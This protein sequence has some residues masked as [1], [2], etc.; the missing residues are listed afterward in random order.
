MYELFGP[1]EIGGILEVEAG[2]GSRV[3]FRAHPAPGAASKQA[4]EALATIVGNAEQTLSSF[5]PLHFDAEAQRWS[6]VKR[7]L[8]QEPSSERPQAILFEKCS[9]DGDRAGSVFLAVG[10]QILLEN[11]RGECA[12]CGFCFDEM[13]NLRPR[14]CLWRNGPEAGRWRVPA[15]LDAA[16][17]Q[18]RNFAAAPT[19]DGWLVAVNFP[20]PVTRLDA[21]CL[22]GLAVYEGYFDVIAAQVR[23]T[24]RAF[25]Y[26]IEALA[27]ASEAADGNTGAHIHRVN[28]YS[29]A[30]AE[31]LGMSSDFVERISYSAQMHDVGKLHIP[32]AIL[33]KPGPLT[34]AE[35]EVMKRHKT[36]G[37]Q[38]LGDSPR[39]AMARE[40]ALG[41]HE[42]WD[43]SG[44]PLRLRG[45]EIPLSA[46]IVML[47]DVYDALRS[48]RPYKDG[49]DH[50]SAY[51]AL[52]RGDGRTEPGHF[53]PAILAAFTRI[54]A[55]F[56]KI[57][58]A[59]PDPEPSDGRQATA[60]T[61]PD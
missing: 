42:R 9:R 38:I 29:A 15:E 12:R 20:R 18:I 14:Q 22:R 56:E 34:P 27:R 5:D 57:F 49:S 13:G 40:I 32:A 3:G 19:A 55:E 47:A 23:E 2:T 17:D 50:R 48:R 36:I 8:V 33:L 53:D 30:L 24:E 52:T 51:E 6:L 10:G 61:S 60:R 26:T 37:A 28:A 1:S 54:H 21:E 59:H 16:V 25:R 58:R 4:V 41:H 35:F 11:G 31:A 44:Y 43:G 7:L 46:R 39:L 45:Y